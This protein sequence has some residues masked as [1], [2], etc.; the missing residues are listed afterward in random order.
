MALFT[1]GTVN[2][3]E[4]GCTAED[5]EVGAVVVL[6]WC[7]IVAGIAITIAMEGNFPFFLVNADER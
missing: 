2:I 5:V 6:L 3:L 7:E 4:Q 1:G